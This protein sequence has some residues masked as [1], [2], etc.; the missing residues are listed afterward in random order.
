MQVAIVAAVLL[1][2]GPIFLVMLLFE[3]NGWKI[4]LE[5]QDHT[6]F[7]IIAVGIIIISTLLGIPTGKWSNSLIQ[8]GHFSCL[9]GAFLWPIYVMGRFRRLQ[10]RILDKISAGDKRN[11]HRAP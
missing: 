11:F 6:G 8:V 1:F 3:R 4:L 10:D 7:I 2:L 9:L 5:G